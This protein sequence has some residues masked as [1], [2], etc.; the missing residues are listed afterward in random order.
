MSLSSFAS[1]NT[2]EPFSF[3]VRIFLCVFPPYLRCFC[4]VTNADFYHISTSNTPS[5]DFLKTT[6]LICFGISASP[7]QTLMD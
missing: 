6:P 4:T 3:S 2:L 1:R 5:Y 7:E